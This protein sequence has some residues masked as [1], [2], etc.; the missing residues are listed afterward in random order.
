MLLF[1]LWFQDKLAT[2]VEFTLDNH[3]HNIPAEYIF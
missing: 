2:E 3:S 1:A